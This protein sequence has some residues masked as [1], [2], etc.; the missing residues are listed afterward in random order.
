MGK[1]LGSSLG[2]G[3]G[4]CL[5]GIGDFVGL[6][7]VGVAVGTPGRQLLQD[8]LHISIT[9]R[10]QYFAILFAFPASH[11]HPFSTPRSL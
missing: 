11:P 9:F 1:S 10:S 6:G 8:F 4:G 2:D 7:F 3:V 5:L